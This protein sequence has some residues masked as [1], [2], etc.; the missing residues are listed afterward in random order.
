MKVTINYQYPV[1]APFNSVDA[2]HTTPHTGVDFGFPLNA[3]V[4]NIGDGV[5]TFTQNDAANELGKFVK[6]HLNDGM[7][8]IYGHLNSIRVHEGQ[9]IHTKD[10]IGLSGSTGRSSAPHLHLQIMQDGIPIDPMHYNFKD[11]PWYDLTGRMAQG[12]EV[13][14][15][16]F[17]SKMIHFGYFCIDS[18]EVLLPTMALVGV[19]WWMV[20]FFPKSDTWSLKLTGS[21]LL[22]FLFYELIRYA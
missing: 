1:T 12:F 6:V 13:S 9:V 11:L 17:K 14:F 21:S 16:L 7:D 15:E 2:W 3:P 19:L 22:I 5:V 10:I 20:P 8:V 18:L 4:P